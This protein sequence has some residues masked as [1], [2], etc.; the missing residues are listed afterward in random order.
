VESP[1]FTWECDGARDT[2]ATQAGS[3][4]LPRPPRVLFLAP[5]VYDYLADGVFH[6]LVQLL[7]R[8]H[9]VDYPRQE[10]YHEDW[11]VTTGPTKYA[12]LHFADRRRNGGLC[13]LEPQDVRS[14]DLVV[15]GRLHPELL[16]TLKTVLS[17][18]AQE[19]LVYLDG[20]DDPYLRG[21]MW[22]MVALYFKRELLVP[23]AASTLY[24]VSKL[25]MGM[26]QNLRWVWDWF[27]SP[28]RHW[29]THRAICAPLPFKRRLRPLPF[30]IIDVG[31][32]PPY[33]EKE[34]DVAFIGTVTSRRRQV[35]TLLEEW[36]RR[37]NFRL[38]VRI[39]DRMSWLEYLDTLSRTRVC[40][41]VRGAG[42]D[43]YRYWEIP[44][45]GSLLLSER[46]IIEIPNNFE[47][48]K[49]AVF[50]RLPDLKERL[51]QL[52]DEPDRILQLATAG[53]EHLLRHHTTVSRARTLLE[54]WRAVQGQ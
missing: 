33:A 26:R 17:S 31:Y 14:F 40:L 47:D 9:V 7:G 46:P 52:F 2:A 30:G 21:W 23:S 8:E 48:G 12:M 29:G 3:V 15:I 4:P 11:S 41:N 27:K 1:K 44:Y 6:G 13:S 19:R 53:R 51:D 42:I 45:A 43:T 49:H 39:T 18:V 22:R 37:H 10:R 28:A 25:G 38:L 24:M 54:T 16:P 5:P 32:T 36:N 34:Y 50:F 20:M 35:L